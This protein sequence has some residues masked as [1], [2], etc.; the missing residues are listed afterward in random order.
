[1]WTSTRFGLDARGP[2]T[3]SRRPGLGDD[4]VALADEDGEQRQLGRGEGE[5]LPLARGGH[6]PEVDAAGAFVQ[7]RPPRRHLG[8]DPPGS[9]R[10]PQLDRRCPPRWLAT[11]RV[12]LAHG[13]HGVGVPQVDHEEVG[14]EVVEV[15]AAGDALDRADLEALGGERRGEGAPVLAGVEHQA[16]G[17]VAGT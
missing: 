14:V 1:M 16:P 5:I 7:L 17:K 6:R 2:Q 8:E 9:R 12:D 3:S 15:G 11:R 10:R 4:G 13:E